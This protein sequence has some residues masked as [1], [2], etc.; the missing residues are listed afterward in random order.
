MAKIEKAF[1]GKDELTKENF[2]PVVTDV[3]GVPKFLKEAIVG[4]IDTAK[5]GKIKKQQ[6][7]QF[8]K[9]NFEQKDNKERIFFILASVNKKV[10]VPEDFKP[11]MKVLL[12]THPGLEFLQATPEF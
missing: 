1:G 6:F 5:T 9:S 2:D 8:W 10:L 4:K 3:I 7:I 12:D 11:L